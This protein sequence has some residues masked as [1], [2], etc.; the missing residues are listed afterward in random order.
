MP[1]EKA[2]KKARAY[3]ASINYRA[4]SATSEHFKTLFAFWWV[5]W[6]LKYGNNNEG[7]R[8]QRGGR[9]LQSRAEGFWLNTR[10]LSFDV[11]LSLEWM[12]AGESERATTTMREKER[13]WRERWGEGRSVG[14][15]FADTSLCDFNMDI[16]YNNAVSRW[17]LIS[18]RNVWS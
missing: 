1:V 14:V 10:L 16:L 9:V 12:A 8:Y 2:E 11:N 17:N 4:V 18:Q 7:R 5:R 6:C 13:G 15:R 3:Y